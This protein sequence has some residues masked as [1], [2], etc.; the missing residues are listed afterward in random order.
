MSKTFANGITVV[1]QGDGLQFVGMAPD[2]CKTPSP[3]G[4]IPVP[5]P[6]IALSSD[7]A[8]GSKT[9]KIEGNPAALSDSNLKTSSGDE[10]GTA[11]GGV[12]SSKIKGKVKWLLCS[13]DVKF[14]G[15]GVIRFLDDF[16]YNGNAGNGPGKNYGYP[17][18]SEGKPINCDNCGKSI[19]D[20]CHDNTKMYRSKEADQQAHA[21]A[22]K[23]RFGT[24]KPMAGALEVTC[25]N[26]AS[27][28]FKGVAGDPSAVL[29]VNTIKSLYKN[30]ATGKPLNAAKVPTD[31]NE[32]GNCAEQ[33]ALYSAYQAGMAPPKCKGNMSVYREDAPQKACETCQRILT[34]MLCTNDT[35]PAGGRR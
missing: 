26:G 10:A 2:V 16:M 14:E 9:V 13:T 34:S 23:V 27:K 4:P 31:R 30:F 7:L 3:G 22:L 21:L 15:K 33:K 32:P 24:K 6:N 28:V 11:G 1:H 35:P 12:V 20:P 17:G 5:Y 8:D 29:N 18:P 19:D 25:G